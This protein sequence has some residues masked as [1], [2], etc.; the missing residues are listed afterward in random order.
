MMYIDGTRDFRSRIHCFQGT[1]TISG[2]RTLFSE[3]QDEAGKPAGG[4]SQ[5]RRAFLKS[6]D[7][8]VTMG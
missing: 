3:A 4:C 1:L 2:S 6:G 5:N 7:P 8:Q